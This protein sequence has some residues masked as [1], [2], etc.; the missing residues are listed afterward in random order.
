MKL[1]KL[2]VKVTLPRIIIDNPM[3]CFS[4]KDG[5]WVQEVPVNQSIIKWMRGKNEGF[6][7]LKMD[8]IKIVSMRP[9]TEA[10]F[11]GEEKPGLTLV[12]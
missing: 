12:K 6:F 11:N 4:T 5:S 3:A 8:A 7:E 10:K 1:K 9:I 2:L